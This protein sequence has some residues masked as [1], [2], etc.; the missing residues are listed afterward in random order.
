KRKAATAVN[1]GAGI[2]SETGDDGDSLRGQATFD[3]FATAEI[4]TRDVGVNGFLPGAKKTMRG[5]HGGDDGRTSAAVA[6]AGMEDA[7]PGNGLA[8]TVFAGFA[9][10]EEHGARA[11]EAEVGDFLHDGNARFQT[12]V[13]NGWGEEREEIEDVDDVGSK[14]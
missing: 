1:G 10:A 5:Q 13:M 9:V 7:G 6:I 12:G 3:E 14:G 4:G 8:D 2:G 11:D